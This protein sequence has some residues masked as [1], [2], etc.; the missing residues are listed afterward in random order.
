[1]NDLVG[2]VP[3]LASLFTHSSEDS[4]FGLIQADVGQVD[5][6]TFQK[7]AD[8]VG[9][10][11]VANATT[12]N[13]LAP[14]AAGADKRTCARTFLQTFGARVY[15]APIT[16]SADI[17]RHLAVF[18]AGA[19]TSYQQ[20]IDLMLRAMLQAP[21]FLYRV[22][23]GTTE[24]V[25][26]NAVKLS[27]FEVAARLSY[28]LWNTTPD[29][30][31]IAAAA[32]G[33]LSTKEGVAMQ[34]SRMLADSK[35]QTLL[36]RFLES[37]IHLSDVDGLVKDKTL[38]PQ[39]E[40]STLKASMI[41]QAR[42]FF[43]DLLGA[44]GGK[45]ASLLTSSKVF[46][47]QDLAPYYGTTAGSPTFQSVTP[48]GSIAPSGL[49]TLPAFLSLLAKPDSSSP[50]YRG[51]FVREEMLCQL[52]PPPPAIVPEPPAVQAGVSTRERFKQHEA[53]PSCSGCHQQIDPIGLGF[54]NYDALGHFRSMDSGQPVDASGEVRDPA[55][56]AGK[57]NGVVELGQKLAASK[58]VQECMARQWF[59]FTLSRFEQ[60][61]D[62]CSMS[63]IVTKFRTDDASLNSLPLAL[64]QSDAFLYRH[65]NDSQVSP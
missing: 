12:F 29:D 9:S 58:G 30:K 46:A 10:T 5:L 31:L 8:L 6:E 62:A 21:R 26:P 52:L 16:D 64:I 38:F 35:G 41:A 51:K 53:D 19:T 17:D 34:L 42:T 36:R 11:V 1:V 43:D 48:Q 4:A 50:I 20:G 59:R 61:V 65:P 56:I 27:G 40:S 3:S 55:D 57:F 7:A 45:M 37:W 60:E 2:A 47:N 22:E 44:Q 28:A 13:N 24:K 32:A 39:W 14:C 49:L 63:A 15:R 33:M 18:D 54:E 23:V 25:G